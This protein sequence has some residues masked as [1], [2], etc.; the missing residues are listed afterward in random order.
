[1]NL[2]NIAK[3]LLRL[4]Q[5]EYGSEN[6]ATT[7]D[8]IFVA[9]RLFQVLKSFK[10]S[11]FSELYTYDTLEFED[12][13]DEMTDSEESND[14]M[15]NEEDTDDEMDDYDETDHS[16]LKNR[17]TLE[18]MEN[19]IEWVDEH[20][21]ARFAT[22]SNRFRKIKSMNYITK[23]REYIENNGTRLE[24]LKQIE[25][26]MFDEFYLKRT[27]EK[28]A[29]HDTDLELYAIQKARELNWDTFKANAQNWIESKRTLISKYSSH[30]ILNSDHCSFQQEYVPPR[31]LSFTGERTTEV[32][33]KKKYNITHSYTVQ[34][35]TS[36]NGHLL[37]KFLL[38]LQEKENTFGTRVQQNLIIP[39]NV[40]VRASKS[41]KSSDEKHHTFLNEV[42]RPLVGK[43]FLLFLDAW[44]TQTD[45]TKFRAVFPNQDTQLLIFPE[46][47][48]DYIQPQGLS[49]FRSWRFI[50]EKIE[51]YTYIN[52]TEITLSDRQYFI[53]MHSVI[54]NQLSAPQFKNLIK[55]GFMQAR[56]ANE[57]NGHIEKPKDVCFKFYDLYCSVNN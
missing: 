52:R 18:E 9:E 33:A 31:T 7:T 36:A 53:N 37:D 34:P 32:A 35:V 30:P 12:E 50:H 40:V 19:I 44:K 27:I 14:D 38:I 43:K 1:M 39:P 48:T 6:S 5:T 51:N 24:K 23:F 10:D 13:Y 26:F 16:D 15:T 2:L 57:T 8:E 20:P 11:Y 4:T 21:N 56:I 17:L 22:I 54:H 47:S 41:G 3:H 45:L 42:L 46:G 49:L 25:A 29:L 55:N 28:E